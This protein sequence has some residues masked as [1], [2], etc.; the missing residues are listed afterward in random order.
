MRVGTSVLLK[1]VADGDN[2]AMVARA[3]RISNLIP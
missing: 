1:S 2:V 3:G